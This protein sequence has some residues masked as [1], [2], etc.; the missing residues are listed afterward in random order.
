MVSLP[1]RS[2]PRL[3]S[4]G[5]SLGVNLLRIRHERGRGP[6]RGVPRVVGGVANLSPRRSS[7]GTN[8][9]TFGARRPLTT[10]VEPRLRVRL[11]SGVAKPRSLSLFEAP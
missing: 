6:L 1:D 2:E 3:R 11:G 8:L 7:V 4:S 10:N 9:R 5:L